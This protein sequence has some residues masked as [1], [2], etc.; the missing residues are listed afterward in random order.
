[1][2]GIKRTEG[3]TNNPAAVKAP[4]AFSTFVA[5]LTSL[6]TGIAGLITAI[7]K[8][9][10]LP[11]KPSVA[12]AVV[13]DGAFVLAAVAVVCFAWVIVADF[14]SRAV[15][16]SAA[17]TSGAVGSS[18]FRVRTKVD[19]VAYHVLGVRTTQPDAKTEFLVCHANGQFA[20]I[21]Q[22]TVDFVSTA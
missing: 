13:I 7:Y 9:T 16:Q 8:A 10:H 2:T 19:K 14:R 12:Q 18:G 3:I 4:T 6:A 22:D 15:A 5:G 20:W 11:A 17:L 21:A 1:M